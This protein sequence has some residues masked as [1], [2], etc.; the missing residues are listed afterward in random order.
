MD[1][2]TDPKE[3]LLDLVDPSRILL[4]AGL[5]PYEYQ[6]PILRSTHKRILMLWSRQTSKSTTAA[7]L[8]LHKALFTPNALVLGVSPSMR[9]SME[10]MRKCRELWKEGP[11]GEIGASA[12]S[13]QKLEFANGSRIISLPG[14]SDATIRGYSAADLIV[15]DEAA[16]TSDAILAAVK[17]IL[18]IS[19]GR[20][21]AMCTPRGAQGW[22]HT[23]W[24][25]EQQNWFRSKVVAT[26]CPNIG[27]EF[28]EAERLELGEQ[29]YMQEYECEFLDATSS[30]FNFDLKDIIT[31]EPA[32]DLELGE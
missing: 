6:L 4:K 21:V 19:N 18:A 17:P 25:D 3:H 28:L 10:L 31:D 12:E 15:I 9:Q 7:A 16:A 14:D 5:E 29:F 24:T 22:F 30:I 8:M 23:A 11:Q 20:L 27:P 1:T 32:I 26:D 2:Q 13:L